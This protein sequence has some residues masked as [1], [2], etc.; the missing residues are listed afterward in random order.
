MGGPY[1]KKDYKKLTLTAAVATILVVL[2][3]LLMMIM[4]SGND[5]GVMIVC[6]ML[7][8]VLAVSGLDILF[9]YSGQ[10]SLGHAAFFV[11]GAY[12]TGL[13]NMYFGTPLYITIP[14]A[15]I[16]SAIM[17]GLLAYPAS[18]LKFHFLALATIAFGEITFNFLYVSPGG[19]TKD[20]L[21]IHVVGISFLKN[22]TTWYYFLLFWV[23]L[24][25]LVKYF[26]VNSR[27]GRAFVAIRENTHAADGMGINVRW[28]KI[29]AFMVSAFYTGL[30]GALFVHFIKYISPETAQQKQSV[31]FLTMLLFGGSGSMLGP[32]IGVVVV[33][34]LLEVIR[35]FQEYQMLLFGVLL[36][37]VIIALPGGLYGGIKDAVVSYKRRK[38]AK[39]IAA[40]KSSEGGACDA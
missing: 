34:I 4:G 10:V 7:I 24:A 12:T 39:S 30:S 9:G 36:L 6:I 25:L 15:A 29:V 8:Y 33:M 35:P 38:M 13:L 1:L 16:F 40:G 20:Y 2:P 3:F 32:I 19:F 5:Y 26:L 14:A 31:L 18:K 27:T 17:G 37:T 28:N 23:S 11:I 21:G 22:Y